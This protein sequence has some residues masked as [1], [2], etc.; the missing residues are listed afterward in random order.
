M[1]KLRN[2][3]KSFRS[4]LGML[5]GNWRGEYWLHGEPVH[6]IKPRARID[7]NKRYIGFVFQQ[8]HLLDDLTVYENLEIPLSYRN[9]KKKDREAIVSVRSRTL[10]RHGRHTFTRLARSSAPLPIP[11]AHARLD[12]E[13]AVHLFLDAPAESPTVRGFAGILREG[14]EGEPWKSVLDVPADFYTSMGLEVVVSP[15]R[16]RGMGAILTRLKRQVTEQ[17]GEGAR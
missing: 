9:V 6:A 17:L 12:G 4:I 15:L 11:Q 10:P 8:H 1:I 5:D 13:G 2:V 7:L 16:L 3:E 14:L